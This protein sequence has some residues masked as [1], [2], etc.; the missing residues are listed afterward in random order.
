MAVVEVKMP[1]MGE[2]VM[3]A[4]IISWLKKEGEKIEEEEGLLEV[5]TDKVD[6][7]V[8]SMFTGVLKEILAAGRRTGT[9]RPVDRLGRH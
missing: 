2:S 9:N 3:E 1:Q 5:A 8:P 4:T 7:E 6:T